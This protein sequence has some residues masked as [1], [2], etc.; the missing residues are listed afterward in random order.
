ML[1]PVLADAHQALA[2]PLIGVSTDGHPRK[3][4]FPLHATGVATTPIVDAA[5]AF[6][7]TLDAAQR[8]KVLLDT[9]AQERRMWF[10]IH[11]N[12]FR[13]GLMLEELGAR[14]RG[15]ALRLME[16][17]LSARG[18]EQARDIMRLNALLVEITTRPE[19]YGEWPYFVTLFGM[20]SADL[21]WGWQIDGHHLNLNFFV[22]GDQLVFTP[23]FMGSEPCSVAHGPLAGTAVFAPEARTGLALVQSLDPGQKARAILR[24]SIMPHALPP[25]LNHFIDGRMQAGAFKDNAVIPY[26]G[27]RASDLSD[28]QRHLLRDLLRTYVGWARD[29]HAAVK[30]SEVELHLDETWFAW[31]GASDG[32]GPFYYRVQSPVILI[33]FDHHPGIV[34]DNQAPSHHHIHTIM[35]T[36]NGGDYGTDLLRQHHERYDHSTGR[37]IERR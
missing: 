15:A 8:T 7:A 24:D 27:V 10:N 18:F 19:E 22:L 30:M 29:D 37:H 31:M 32:E 14:Q 16:A 25:E 28:T 35:R 26:A 33:E 21:P 9:E 2:Q 11:P 36:P 20:P 23:S 3:D 17:T 6:L 4:L 12:V 1:Q 13:H 5:R 34:F